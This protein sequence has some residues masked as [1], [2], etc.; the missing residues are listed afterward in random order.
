[1]ENN[2]ELL[3]VSREFSYCFRNSYDIHPLLFFDLT[4]DS[5]THRTATFDVWTLY[6]VDIESDQTNIS[7]RVE[8][9]YEQ[10]Y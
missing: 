1:M 9:P 2:E 7:L 4:R 6:L 8:Y 3:L 5:Q 10:Y